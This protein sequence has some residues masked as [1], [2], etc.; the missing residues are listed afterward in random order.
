MTKVVGVYFKNCHGLQVY[1]DF[2]E[3][4]FL[5][6][7]VFIK[8]LV[9]IFWWIFLSVVFYKTM[10]EFYPNL[11]LNSGILQD[12]DSLQCNARTGRV[13]SLFIF[14]KCLRKM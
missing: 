1:G 6:K 12:Q 7:G 4:Y 8:N 10:L 11:G 3:I 13:F 14:D 9:L 2:Y 5:K